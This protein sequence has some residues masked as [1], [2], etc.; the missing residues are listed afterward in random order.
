MPPG[1]ATAH[2]GEDA[3]MIWSRGRSRQRK[4]V[5]TALSAVGDNG[6]SL[7]ALGVA[8]NISEAHLYSIL[9]DLIHAGQ[10]RSRSGQEVSIPGQRLPCYQLVSH[11]GSSMV[12]LSPRRARST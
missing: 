8:V 10:V 11:A 3:G 6:M 1:S 7:L 4:A 5:V 9:G 2:H 12:G